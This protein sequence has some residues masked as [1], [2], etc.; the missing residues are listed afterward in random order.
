MSLPCA[1][2]VVCFSRSASVHRE[3]VHWR[4]AMG[5]TSCV[6]DGVVAALEV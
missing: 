1:T 6:D 4:G 5:S 2:P 3:C